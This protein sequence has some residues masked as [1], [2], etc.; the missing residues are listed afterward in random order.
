[1]NL[2]ELMI[3]NAMKPNIHPQNCKLQCFT[4]Y[5][6]TICNLKEDFQNGKHLKRK[7]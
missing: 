5:C 6:A 1:M 7:P 2:D 4:H 3:Y